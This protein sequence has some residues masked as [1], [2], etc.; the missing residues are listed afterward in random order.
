M[1]KVK[2]NKSAVWI[3]VAIVLVVAVIAAVLYL[4]NR[5]PQATPT[6]ASASSSAPAQAASSA[7]GEHYPISAA[8]TG[9]ASASSTPLP[10][11]HASDSDV[12]QAFSAMS[13]GDAKALLKNSDLIQ[14]AVATID[15]LPG[16][17]L[18]DNILPVHSPKGSFVVTDSN[19]QTVMDA[20]NF[21][22]YSAYMQ[23]LES[24]DTQA[25]VNWYVAHY[26]L[27]QQA[28]REQGYPKG[29]F[30]DRL[31][32]VIDMLLATPNADGPVVLDRPNVFYTYAQPSLESLSAGQKLLL[33][34]GPEN[35]AKI[36]AK[37]RAIRTA[38]TA[39]PPQAP[40]TTSTA[41]TPAGAAS[42]LPAH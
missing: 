6:P 9:P 41:P 39:H 14:R 4:R 42:T 35:E 12:V 29:Y 10:A 3:V 16:K 32:Q 36:K 19:G 27:F 37:L 11:L 22:R 24:V 7:Q 2:G 23:V 8:S 13:G 31:I 28:Y 18:N 34:M 38:L 21:D 17:K 40:A 25:L 15:A 20:R 30:N 26:P 33:R 5:T 1:S